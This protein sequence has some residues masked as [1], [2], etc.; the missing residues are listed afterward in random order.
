LDGEEGSHPA[1]ASVAYAAYH[2]QVL[3]APEAPVLLAVCND[4]RGQSGADARQLF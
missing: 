1:E 3:C 2:Q 4:T